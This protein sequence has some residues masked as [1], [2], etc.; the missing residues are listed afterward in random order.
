LRPALLCAAALLAG[1]GSAAAP[2]QVK[3]TLAVEDASLRK[4]GSACSGSGGYVYVRPGA[5]Y[6]IAAGGEV[7][8]R[9][10][11]PP[12]VAE[13]RGARAIEG[14]A[15]EPTTCA[16][17]FS[18][19]LPS[20][21]RY[22]LRLDR[23]AQ[24][25]FGP[26]KAVRLRA[27]QATSGPAVAAP[28]SKPVS[29]AS[30]RLPGPVPAGARIAPE[31]SSAPAA[32]AFSAT[33]LNGTRVSGSQLWATR[34]VVVAFTASW[35]ARCPA[36]QPMLNALAKKYDGLVAFVGVA[37]GDKPADLKRYTAEHAVPYATGIDATGTSWRNYA[38]TEP[39]T[40]AVIG[41]GGRL[42]RGWSVDVDQATLDGVLSGLVSR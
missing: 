32:P 27:T 5:A 10:V 35:C 28:P 1:C 2:P 33:L 15:V 18:A 31:D 25:S 20:R 38:V 39:P 36:R 16:V 17:T 34:P 14:A 11:L 24:L 42:L 9:G 29:G 22:T 7:L 37:Q 23:G 19:S 8:A 26:A 13:R 41:K 40:I 12:G 4:P 21:S 3:I 6:E 30:P